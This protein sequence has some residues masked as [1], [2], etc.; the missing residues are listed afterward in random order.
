M[1]WKTVRFDQLGFLQTEQ[2][3]LKTMFRDA[4]GPSPSIISEVDKEVMVQTEEEIKLDELNAEGS[5]GLEQGQHTGWDSEQEQNQK[6]ESETE[7][8]VQEADYVEEAAEDQGQ[9]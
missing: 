9:A 6:L 1:M 5:G 2:L 7:D 3:I 8:R 4:T